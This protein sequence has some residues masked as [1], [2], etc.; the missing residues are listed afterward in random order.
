MSL[1][2]NRI[3]SS[4][5]FP[6]SSLSFRSFI[7]SHSLIIIINGSGG[8]SS[9]CIFSPLHLK[10]ATAHCSTQMMSLQWQALLPDLSFFQSFASSIFFY[11]LS[12]SKREEWAWLTNNCKGVRCSI[13]VAVFSLSASFLKPKPITNNL[14]PP[15]VSIT[16][17]RYKHK[18]ELSRQFN[19]Q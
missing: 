17:V 16:A 10:P 6:F 14:P 8:S 18:V 5:F 2:F 4:F 1:P 9:L 3:A 11:S 19:Q 7:F 15:A 12:L 13:S